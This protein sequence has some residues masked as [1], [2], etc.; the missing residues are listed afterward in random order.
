[1][2]DDGERPP[3]V[4][5]G[6]AAPV[7][8]ASAQDALLMFDEHL[9]IRAANHAALCL[10]GFASEKQLLACAI[11]QLL[12]GLTTLENTAE[13]EWRGLH[14]QGTDLRLSLTLDE[15]RLDGQQR[16]FV[17][18][19][20]PIGKKR[21]TS[22]HL[23]Q[24]DHD[25]LTGCINRQYFLQ[26]LEQALNECRTRKQGLAVLFIDLDG[27]KQVNDYHGHRI[28]DA[29]LRRVAER[30]QNGLREADCLGRIGGDEFAACLL[31]SSPQ[32]ASD[33]AQ[34]L[35]DSLAQPFVIDGIALS[36]GASI[37]ISL[38]STSPV[39]VAELM[40][41][42]DMAMYRAKARGGGCVCVFGDQLRQLTAQRQHSL[43]RLRSALLDEQLELHYQPQCQ[44]ATGQ[45][46]ALSA[47]LYWR[48]KEYGLLPVERFMMLAEEQGLLS[49]IE[50]WSLQQVCRDARQ[51]S[52]HNHWPGRLMVRVHTSLL[53]AADFAE[54]LK[55][56]LHENGVAAATL[57]LEIVASHDH[58]LPVQALTNLRKLAALGVGLIGPASAV[59][60]WL[61]DLNMTMLTIDRRTVAALW[62]RSQTVRGLLG[63]AQA[64]ALPI[65]AQGIDDSAQLE[66]LRKAGCSFGQGKQLGLP[67][68]LADW[69]EE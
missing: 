48:S 21:R 32:T 46:H 49:D 9:Q 44:L 6:S 28:G 67:L 2:K 13:Q 19:C 53:L 15:L 18:Y 41:E 16:L 30:F 56:T 33:V 66:W 7:A 14:R 39:T 65:L 38:L 47:L 23:S 26:R 27:F 51:M 35:I 59:L 62:H 42:A 36:V 8:C 54:W 58:P 5:L 3:V 20:Q 55:M 61:S 10:F 40:H 1:M 34:R 45:V 69:L 22:D 29:L 63:L 17:A 43:E 68:P 11:T 12:P 60:S 52:T 31:D 37:G 25:S 50:R 57:Q 24:V 4:G 64:L